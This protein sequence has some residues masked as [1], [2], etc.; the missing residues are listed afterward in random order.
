HP[1]IVA[2]YDA[3]QAGNTHFLA[4]EFVDGTDL[5]SVVEQQGPLP[6]AKACDAIRQAAT[7]LQHAHERGMVH[8]DI[9]PH[10]LMISRN[11]QVR[12]LDFGLAG[13]ATETA[14]CDADEET[15]GT[16][17]EVAAA[18]LTT[19]GSVMGTPDYIAPEQA[20][21]AHFADIRADIYSLGG[22]LCFLLTGKPP[23]EAAT[24]IDK[25][26]AHVEQPPPALDQLRDD[27]PPGLARVI[28]RILAKDPADRFQTPEELADALRPFLRPM[29]VRRRPSRAVLTAVLA[30]SVVLM[31]LLGVLVTVGTARGRMVIQSE[32]GDVQVVLKQGGKV[33]ETIDAATG[34]TVR[35]LPMGEY[36]VELK[37]SDNDVELSQHGF[38]M[39]RLG[40]VIVA[41]K[42]STEGTGT[43]RAFTTADQPITT[44]GV[45]VDDGGWKIAAAQP[46]SVHLFDVSEPHFLPGPFHYRAKLKTENVQGRAYLEMWVRFPGQGEFFSKGFQHALSGTNGWAEYEIPFF[47]KKGEEPD[48]V[49][50]NVTIE[51]TGTVWIKDIELRGRRLEP[52]TSTSDKSTE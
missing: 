45:T 43:V 34:T 6:V 26:K 5:A 48:L 44:D 47:L 36:E 41:A 24:V 37:G 29:Q 11:G 40:Q 12:I 2:A 23:F 25:L 50:L 52:E 17:V 19:M 42:W 9:K 22:T 51:G 28:E 46:R 39:K 31:L 10:N 15:D 1:N 13:F 32:V 8:R 3:E 33:I 14:L 16:S 18:H 49:K 7:A 20:R 38:T 4:M 21:D 35:W 30:V 27:V